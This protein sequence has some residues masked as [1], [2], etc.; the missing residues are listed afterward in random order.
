MKLATLREARY[1]A[2]DRPD[3]SSTTAAMAVGAFD[4]S[5]PVESSQGCASVEVKLQV[6]LPIYEYM[7]RLYLLI[8]RWR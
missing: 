5:A 2:A 7:G 6:I 1:G 3:I 4:F 8:L